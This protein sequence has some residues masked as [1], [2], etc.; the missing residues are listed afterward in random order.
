MDE[1]NRT[2]YLRD[3]YLQLQKAV[4]DFDGRVLTIKAWS[5]SFGLATIAG[6]FLSHRPVVFVLAS[7]ASL[8]FWFV[9]VLW[10]SFQQAYYQRIEQ[11]EKFFA[12][13]STALPPFQIHASW[14]EHWKGFKTGFYFRMSFW[15]H[16]CFPHVFVIVAALLMFLLCRSGHLKA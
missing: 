3:E 1:P 2:E 13:W 10:K 8:C 11:I 9:E 16:V 5:V 14:L 15:P 4:E 6:A 12:G 7:L